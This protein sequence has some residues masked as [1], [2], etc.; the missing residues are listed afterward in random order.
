MP[1]KTVT[2]T[3]KEA[4]KKLADVV[5]QARE[6]ELMNPTAND[7][8]IQAA[9]MLQKE[10]LQ[11]TDANRQVKMTI[12]RAYKNYLGIFDEP[13]DPYTNRRK[14]FSPLTH[15][16]VDATSKPVDITYKSIR[17][18]PLND[19]SRP[20]AKLLN[21]I[22]PYFFQLMEFDDLL[23]YLKQ[24]VAWLGTQVTVQDWLYEERDDSTNK[25]ATTKELSGFAKQ[26]KVDNDTELV[27]EDRPRIR[28]INIM[29]I[30]LPA[31]SESI[32]WAVKNS[33]VIVRSVHTLA[34]IQGNPIFDDGVKANLKGRIMQTTNNDDSTSL[35]RFSMSGYS[36]GE[37]RSQSGG[38][39][40]RFARPVVALYERYGKIPKSWITGKVEDALTLV[41]GIVTCVA[42]D[43]S[44]SNMQ[45]LCI[46]VSPFGE[47]G[48]FEDCRFF[49]LPNRYWGEGVGERLIPYQVW[50]NEI[51]NN[52][53]NNELL[54]QHRMF[55]YKKGKV[56]PRQLFARPG[57]GIAV[58]N[59][60]DIQALPTPDIPASSFTE[61]NYIVSAAQ[62]SVGIMMT[63]MQKKATATEVNA[64]QIQSG[65]SS[66]E[67]TKALESYLE[68]MVKFHII[69]L[70]K[71]YFKQKKVVPVEIPTGELSML[72]TFN[73]FAPFSKT[74]G[75]ERFLMMD[76]PSIFDGEFAVTVD[77]ESGGQSK[78]SQIN[79]LDNAIVLAS[80]I[81]NSGLN[82][83]AAFRKKLELAGIFDDR[84]FEAPEAPV[85]S[86]VTA[87]PSLTPN[88]Q[89][90]MNMAEMPGMPNV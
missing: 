76:D 4:A 64:N 11:Y 90:N 68:R 86:G 34:S 55:V 80:K 23:E 51:I 84:L 14:I 46:R 22:L 13:I 16:V 52:R 88:Q 25:E 81:Q 83:P 66:N 3:T 53:R 29:D 1:R 42:D 35:N 17:I 9:A 48:P 26:E 85:A 74:I 54:V 8:Y 61:D 6:K 73:G 78:Q 36:V 40:E 58:E 56:D 43:A 31:T 50:H 41:D 32:A 87:P 49:V 59:M 82:I 44:E 15:D 79:T 24:R 10:K 20:K 65:I 89:P 47:R 69:P 39:Q 12:K 45:T 38:E 37:L 27:K 19:K 77:I 60:T 7:P 21:M 70:L 67:F 33:S 62:R 18:K 75:D 63:P 71:R 2:L 28:L 30:F 5:L 57:G 72:D